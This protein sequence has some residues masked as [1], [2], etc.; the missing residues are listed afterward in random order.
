MCKAY[1][2]YLRKSR[3]DREDEAAGRG[4][5]LARHRAALLELAGRRQLPVAE[6]Y[7]EV[8]SGESVAARPQMR[9][10]LRAVEAGRYAGVLVME[11][12]RLARGNTR[13]QGLVAETFQCSGTRIITPARDYDPSDEADEEYFEF[14]L[15]MSRRE[16]K[17]I[18]RRLQRGRAASL[19]EGKYI[20]G[21]APYGYARKKLTGQKGYTLE[22]LPQRAEVVRLIFSLYTS[23][24]G[25]GQYGFLAL[26]RR[27]DALGIPSPGGGQW[28]P[29]TVKDILRNPV[30]AG[31]L[32][33]AHRPAVKTLR[34]GLPA[35]SRPVNREAKVLPGLHPPI[36]E[37]AVWA[38]A[39]QTLARRAHTPVS[40]GRSLANPLSGLVFC[41]LC[42]RSMERRRYRRGRETLVCPGKDC[43][44]MSAALEEV[45]DAI[46]KA[47][48]R[49][50]AG[51]PL[52][53][54]VFRRAAR[55][56]A[57]PSE[58]ASA[59]EGSLSALR[60]R[61]EALPELLEEGVYTP[62][63]YA[64]R[65]G[66]LEARISALEASLSASALQEQAHSLPRSA[67]PLPATL[68]VS[69][70]YLALP[71]AQDRNELL[72]ALL[73]R[74]EYR[75]TAGGRWNAQSLE[76]FVFP[77]VRLPATAG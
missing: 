54:A 34:E 21:S 76:L 10:L 23:G 7:E 60:R 33:W 1:S 65:R 74:V 50:L 26:A 45:E 67:L 56:N 37:P 24:D 20:A 11:V 52:D 46:V 57:A 25:S 16:Y 72:K 58:A 22:I 53:S 61:L 75:K 70:L 42:G 59:L 43:A 18:N 63:L 40:G 47:L 77:R 17:A 62:Q 4:D 68:E 32:R 12:E 55:S 64:R 49:H 48:S 13:D 71:T 3:A 38:S 31:M 51:Y 6:V 36:V 8:V 19:S 2:I 41:A 73:S 28:Q 35:A 66:A 44:N 5:T 14:G 9:R 30:Y 69:R 29:G 27:L 15:F 39:Q